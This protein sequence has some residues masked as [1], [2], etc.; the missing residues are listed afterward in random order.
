MTKFAH[1]PK[2]S[3]IYKITNNV[4]GKCYIGSSVNIQKRCREHI[5]K[6]L[7]K[8]HPN[9]HLQNSFCKYGECSFNFEVLEDVTDKNQLL[10]KEGYFITTLKADYNLA[11]LDYSG[12][13]TLSEETKRKI[14]IKSAEKFVKNPDLVTKLV[15]SRSS[16][17]VWNKGKTGVYSEETIKIMKV[18]SREKNLKRPKEQLVNLISAA[19]KNAE[20][21]RKPVLQL[22]LE[23][24][25]VAEWESLN[26]VATGLNRS[27]GNI[28]SGI[29][30]NKVRYGYY[31][32]Y[33]EIKICQD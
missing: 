31:W 8:T 3:G 1:L 6:L 32:K 19:R 33:K 17:P 21:T 4:N 30:H 15:E 18:A 9:N 28:C 10:Q 25:F 22:D 29:K 26:S 23:G 20:K 12:K 16:N 27:V 11:T 14:G 2:T 7:S 13:K 24:N 5:I